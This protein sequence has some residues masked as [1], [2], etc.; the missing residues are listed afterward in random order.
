MKFLR[1]FIVAIFLII[2]CYLIPVLRPIIETL[3]DW[4]IEII[5]LKQ[6]L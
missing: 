2:V 3:W 4:I 1:M 6:T 5:K